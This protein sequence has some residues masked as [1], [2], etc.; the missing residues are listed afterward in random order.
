MR[1]MVITHSYL[2]ER[3]PPQR[4][5]QHLVAAFRRAGWEVDIVAPAPDPLHAPA[6]SA[7]TTGSEH[8]PSADRSSSAG[9][10]GERILRTPAVPGLQS[11]RR[12]RFL[13][14]AIHAVAAVPVSLRA[15][16]PD[17]LIVTVPALPTA[18]TGLVLTAL[19]RTPLIV[20]M[21]DAWPDLAREAGV[22][23]GPLGLV[24]ERIVT[25][26][27]MSADLVV[28]VTHG[29][30][31]RLR[32]RGVRRVEVVGNGV[33]LSEIDPV[34]PRERTPG[35]LHVLYLGNHG[36][37]QALETVI[38]AAALVQDAPEQIVVR[39][40][41]SGTQKAA[42]TELNEQ[43]GSPVQ[44]L[45]PV[46]GDEL[47]S[48]YAWSDTC[49]VTLRPDWPSFAWTVP[50]K[51]Y[52][53]LAIGRHI[54]GVVTGEA[55]D[56]L[57]QTTADLVDPTPEALADLWRRLARRPELTA[58]GAGR[59]WVQENA[60]LRGLGDDYVTL[61]EQLVGEGARASRRG[62][63][64]HAVHT[65]RLMAD[66][67][68]E[69][70]DADP[71]ELALQISRRLPGGLRGG[72]G[73]TGARW[74][75]RVAPG[76]SALGLAMSGQSQELRERA[77]S[78]LDRGESPR[79][80]LRYADV[81]IADGQQDPAQSILD[82]PAGPG[83]STPGAALVRSRAA[84]SRGAMDEAVEALPSRG[85]A[86]R[87][88][89][90]L[91]SERSSYQG[92]R[93]VV[94]P[95]PGYR[96]E[97]G[98]VLHVLTN[99]LPHSG[100]GYAQR[101]HSTLTALRDQGWDV[102]GVT[103]LGWPV[104]TGVLTAAPLDRI[105]GIE[106][107]RLLPGGMRGGLSERL[108]QHADLLRAHCLAL[109]PQILHTTTE[110]TN[111][112]VTRAVA[113][114]L[115]IP[116]VYEVRGQRADTWAALRGPEVLTSERYRLFTEREIEAARS[117]DAVITLAQGMRETLVRGGVDP[118][119]LAVCP[120]AVGG[121]FLEEPPAQAQAR[122]A[123]GLD[124]SGE[125]VGT[126]SSLVPYEGLDTLVRSVALLA[127]D[128]PDLK[129]LLVGDGTA[130]PSLETLA[131]R[132]GIRD[133]LV[134]TGRVDRSRVRGYH[135]SLDVF[136]V[137]R[138]DTS[139][140]RSVTPMK[141]VEASATGRPVVASDLPALAELVQHGRTGLLVPAD[142]PQALAETLRGLLDD[143]E[144]RESLGSAGRTWAVTERT[145][146]A[147]AQRVDGL[148]RSVLEARG[149]VDPR[150]QQDRIDA[151]VSTPSWTRPS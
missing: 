9:P 54:T 135:A 32:E 27:Q 124:L 101:S 149:A 3:T 2:P 102:S 8:L 148:Y 37:S 84:S 62:R 90:R 104:I 70:L 55:A 93:P 136:V 31:A 96:P 77:Q 67:V 7:D 107:R 26:S 83:A 57:R 86:G 40:V 128:R 50:S 43:L 147:N 53:L 127:P 58:S 123:V 19:R 72:I 134:V 87:L 56:I 98:R 113:E 138:R 95:V 125:Y 24:M 99:S 97:P 91:R 35:E 64:G 144:C 121:A 28:T 151:D 30:A 129:L 6:A 115:D 106:Y 140:T 81:L 74:L 109:R 114:A 76:L 119:R 13:S 39:L 52:D 49:V 14:N 110:W 48:Q 94:E 103:R 25:R 51:T 117:A 146:A 141:S 143:A 82:H 61:A 88:R 46:H 142:D 34:P 78:A 132:L 63:W 59:A 75:R 116:W 38:R 111:A 45:D 118:R 22:G 71:V 120:N 126:V 10:S 33:D 73:R 145:W 65:V 79:R 85:R 108:Q 11:T 68:R 100:S 80:L 23:P 16:R 5:W 131:E 92:R 12:G 112:V 139:V 41:G 42:L 133:R 137:P 29:F 15:A 47:R 60:D 66:T 44:M 122:R 130:L 105:D 69:H 17:L 1:L 4:R 20:E 36:E 18:V 150:G 21:R 89:E